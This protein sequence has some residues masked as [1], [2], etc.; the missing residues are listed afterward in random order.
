[1]CH[2]MLKITD[3]CLGIRS[4]TGGEDGY[5]FHRKLRE[6]GREIP[7]MV[8]MS[9]RGGIVND[10]LLVMI[11]IAQWVKGEVSIR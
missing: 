9:E 11:Y 5:I 4:G 2:R 10:E 1:M 3:D 7:G 8:E 6:K